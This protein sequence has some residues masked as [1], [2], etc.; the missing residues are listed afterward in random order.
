MTTLPSPSFRADAVARALAT[1]PTR[2]HLLRQARRRQPRLDEAALAVELP[3]QSVEL[4][5]TGGMSLVYR[6]FDRELRR[7]VAVK[8]LR[9][10]L[11]IH[12]QLASTFVAEYEVSRRVR[13]EG[14][15]PIHRT[16]EVSGV[17][18]LVMDWVE[19]R[20]LGAVA[21]AGALPVERVAAIGALIASALAAAHDAG[22][23]HCDVKPDNVLVH[24]A[25]PDQL[26]RV[27]VIDFG[28]AR[29]ADRATLGGGV[30]TGTPLYMAP[31]QW[32][33][34]AEPASDVYALGCVL[35]ELLAGRAPFAGCFSDVMTA[36][37][38]REPEPLLAR[39]PDVPAELAAL[40]MAM[41]A[42]APAQRPAPM[43]EVARR[44]A[45]IAVEERSRSSRQQR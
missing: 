20:T 27:Q 16:G 42:K 5:A 44:L 3:F 7:P 28:V 41:L 18:Y 36:H 35:Y 29:V 37:L 32:Q 13:H 11:A 17:P 45:A 1:V 12:A 6:A 15:V 9:P 8:M 19:G 43:H 25:Q 34:E 14:I 31:E 39:R 22:V 40:V 21:E 38:E 23:V 33:G 2:P 24:Q 26:P 4:V 30:V 10:A